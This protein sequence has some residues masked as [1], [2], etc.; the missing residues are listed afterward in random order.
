MKI[1]C[2][3]QKRSED[4][5][6]LPSTLEDLKF[7]LGTI[8]DIKTTSLEVETRIRDIKERYRCLVNYNLPVSFE[9]SMVIIYFKC[10]NY[11]LNGK[12][13]HL[14]IIKLAIVHRLII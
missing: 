4:L 5:T 3:F 8:S 6:R 9:Y 2:D 14:V 7:V 11:L 10:R 12:T 13:T 1:A